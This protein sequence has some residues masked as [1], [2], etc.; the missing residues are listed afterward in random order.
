MKKG[1]DFSEVIKLASQCI[2]KIEDPG[3]RDV[4]RAALGGATTGAS[5]GWLVGQIKGPDGAAVGASFG[6]LVGGS[7]AVAWVLW[8]RFCQFRPSPGPE[9][10]PSR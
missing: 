1:L 10:L 2:D 8:R 9:L 3:L 7:L 5:I 6:A 4:L